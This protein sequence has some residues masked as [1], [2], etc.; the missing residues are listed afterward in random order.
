M[1]S[2]AHESRRCFEM[3]A[4]FS[5]RRSTVSLAH[6]FRWFSEAKTHFTRKSKF[7]PTKC[8]SSFVTKLA[9]LEIRKAKVDVISSVVIGYYVGRED[10]HRLQRVTAGIS[11]VNRNRSCRLLL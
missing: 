5:S 4:A 7:N 1:Y 10:A 11:S 2:D 6:P 8:R 9:L 3:K